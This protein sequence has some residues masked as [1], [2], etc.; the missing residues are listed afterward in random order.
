MKSSTIVVSLLILCA[1]FEAAQNKAVYRNKEFGI[2]LTAPKGALLCH[3]HGN[4]IDH[5]PSLLLGTQDSRLCGQYSGRRWIGI[6]GGCNCAEES[7]TLHTFLKSECEYDLHNVTDHNG[8]C[9]S[10]PTDLS[11]NGLPSEA[12]RI[13][14]PSGLIE[15]IVVTQ[16]GKPDPDFD[17][18]VPSVNYSLS[19]YTDVSHLDEDLAVFRAVLS[20]VKLAPVGPQR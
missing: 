3:I 4:G 2:F 14:F 5:G 13:G 9:S 1:A 11:V 16:A 17:A 12:V 20:T 7:K 6:F 10:A 15:I 19:L 18:S 8:V